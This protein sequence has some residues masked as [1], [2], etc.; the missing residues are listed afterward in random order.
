MFNQVNWPEFKRRKPTYLTQGRYGIVTDRWQK[1]SDVYVDE[2]TLEFHSIYADEFLVHGV[3][4]QGKKCCRVSSSNGIISGAL[5][6]YCVEM[7]YLKHLKLWPM[8]ILKWLIN[9]F[10]QIGNSATKFL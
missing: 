4:V 8:K 5:T 2:H 9:F 10:I 1:L 7:N 3:D 6:S